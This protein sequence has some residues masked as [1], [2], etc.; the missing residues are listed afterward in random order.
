MTETAFMG[1]TDQRVDEREDGTY[2][3]LVKIDTSDGE[4][5]EYSFVIGAD[6][7]LKSETERN[8][9]TGSMRT[10]QWV[11]EVDAATGD[12]KVTAGDWL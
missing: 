8:T 12:T 10:R 5:Q 6:G 11:Y 3:P 2:V 9:T 7:N 4:W 1:R